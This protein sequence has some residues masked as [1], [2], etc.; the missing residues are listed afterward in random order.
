MIWNHDIHRKFEFPQEIVPVFDQPPRVDLS[1]SLVYSKQAQDRKSNG[2]ECIILIKLND[3]PMRVFSMY[4][5]P[6]SSKYRHRM[7]V[8]RSGMKSQL[9]ATV[10]W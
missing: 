1:N 10:V 3:S 7:K 5:A 6:W 2:N 4:K 8:V 9:K